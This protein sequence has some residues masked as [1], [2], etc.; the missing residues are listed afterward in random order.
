M[1]KSGKQV[2]FKKLLQVACS[3]SHEWLKINRSK[4]LRWLINDLYTNKDY[5]WIR[6]Y[7][8][9]IHLSTA[10]RHLSSLYPE[11]SAIG[12]INREIQLLWTNGLQ[13]AS[14][15][16]AILDKFGIEDEFKSEFDNDNKI[17]FSHLLVSSCASSHEWLKN[18]RSKGLRWIITELLECKEEWMKSQVFNAGTNISYPAEKMRKFY[19]EGTSIREAIEGLVERQKNTENGLMLMKAISVLDLCKI[20]DEFKD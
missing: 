14:V 3:D 15:L 11:N 9:S 2:S 13:K 17:S 19:K 18:N 1:D 12:E 8:P 7:A 10:S 20:D 16:I 5:P 4:G 6:I